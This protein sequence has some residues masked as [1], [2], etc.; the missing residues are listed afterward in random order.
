MK[1]KYISQSLMVILSVGLLC[2]A[3]V[4]AKD[5]KASDL[6]AVVVDSTQ[7]MNE[8]TA[9]KDVQRQ[10]EDKRKEYQK[11][12]STKEEE[13]RKEHEKLMA[14]QSQKP[15]TDFE[16]KQKDFEK[17]V[18]KVKFFVDTRRQKLEEAYGD[19]LGKINDVFMRVV[20]EIAKKKEAAI[21]LQRQMVIFMDKDMDITAEVVT[22]LNKELS[23][24][25]VVF[26]SEKE[27]SQAG[28]LPAK[29]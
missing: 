11:E 9:V 10:I 2:S 17:K 22:A 21:A 18:E 29:P 6:K 15:A 16:Q 3:T 14:E 12:I 24:V 4:Y 26:P 23:K 13:L 28:K 8:S 19:A 1:K 7:V 20:Q 27:A 5:E 25:P